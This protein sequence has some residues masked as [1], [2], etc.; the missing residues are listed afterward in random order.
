MFVLIVP[1]LALFVRMVSLIQEK[2]IEWKMYE[3]Q[4]RAFCVKHNLVTNNKTIHINDDK[5]VKNMVSIKVN[6]DE[7]KRVTLQFNALVE[8]KNKLEDINTKVNL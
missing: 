6:L 1:Y 3:D 8:K 2:A 7:Q 4:V 5:V